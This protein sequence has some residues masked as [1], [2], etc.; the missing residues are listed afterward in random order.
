MHYF[1]VD[2]FVIFFC[3]MAMDMSLFFCE[4]TPATETSAAPGPEKIDAGSTEHQ[5]HQEQETPRE[6]CE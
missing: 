6:E 4:P 3:H 1:S 2:H 5:D